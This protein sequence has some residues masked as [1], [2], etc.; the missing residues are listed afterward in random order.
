MVNQARDIYDKRKK[1][2]DDVELKE[3]KKR[4]TLLKEN[5]MQEYLEQLKKA[6]N[7][8]INELFNQT[9]KFLK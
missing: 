8:K 3:E 2:N 6:K 4:I 9:N 7:T 5:N 1:K